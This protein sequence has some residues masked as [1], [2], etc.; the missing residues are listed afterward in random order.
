MSRLPDDFVLSN[1]SRRGFLKGAS[2]AGVLVLAATW[3]LPEAFAEE[4]KFGAEGMPHGAVDDPKVYVSIATDG[5]VTVIC[6]RSEMGQG[7]RTSLSMVVADELEAD[8][9]RVK[10]QQAPADEARFGNQDTDGSRSMRHWYEPMRRCGAAARTMLELAAAAQWKVPVDECHAQ[11]HKVLHQ[12]SGRELGYGELAAAAS[13]LAVPSRGSLRLKQ[14]SEFR[15]I[16]KEASRAIDGADIVNGRAVFGADVHFDG[17]LYAVIARPPVYGGKVKSVDSSAALKVPGVVK[18]VQI[19]GRPLPSEFQPLGGVAVVA[20]NTWAAIKG[21]E[22]LKIQWDDGPNAGYDSIA[23]RKELEAAALK[24]GKVVRSSGDLDDAL[25]KADSTL[26]ASYY[27]PHLSQSPMEPMVA[28]ARFKDGQCEAWAPSQAPQVTR[29]RVAER[30]GIPFEK[31]TVNITLLGGGFGRK[32][33]PDFVVEAAVLAKEFPGQAI[34]VQWT[35][36]DD[37][38][39]S[40]FHT[41]SAEYLKAGLNQDGMPSGWLHRTVAPSITA[42]FAPG[43][44]HEAPFEIGMGV[45]N[46]AYAI[47][48]LRLENPEAVAHARVGWYRSV[49]NIPHGFAIQSFIDE[50]AHKAGQDPLKYQVKLL[51]P[52]RKIDPRSLSEEWNYG[53]SPER[54]PIDTARIRTVLETA[55][56]AAGWGRELPKGRGL[57]LAVHYSFVTYVAAVIDV[58]VKDDGTVIVHKADIAVDCGPQIN[59]ERIRS[60]FEGACVMGL[61]NAMVGEISFKDGKVQ[62]DNFHMYEVA[63]MSL[64]PKEVAVHLVTPPGEVPLGGVGEPGVPPIAPALCN[65]IFAATGKR[66]RNLPVRYQLQGWQQAKA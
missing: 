6:N 16:G 24:P 27:L 53:E 11:L 50:L 14:P 39:H 15:Y 66:I 19:E 35:R 58:E 42:L 21:R 61:G 49:S 65:A 18:V 55:A 29:E 59:P 47:P 54:Y 3:G 40:Y 46:M 43:M 64:A 1:L 36:E 31:V 45:T 9:A 26:E 22:A 41:V 4:K 44:T 32:S 60:Q 56:K 10:V 34:R 23:Y 28:V 7:V 63:R 48:N 62:Q 52:D 17:M 13:A 2:A 51:G 5:S 57:G 20:K 37:I 38:H 25:A 12:P 33:K 8:W 30:L